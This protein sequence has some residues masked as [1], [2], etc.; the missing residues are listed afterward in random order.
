MEAARAAAAVHFRITQKTTLLF[1]FSSVRTRPNA[2][3][4]L[5]RIYPVRQR[6]D[7]NCDGMALSV[8]HDCDDIDHCISSFT[9]AEHHHGL[10]VEVV[11]EA[12]TSDARAERCRPPQPPH[13]QWDNVENVAAVHK[14]GYSG[15]YLR[16]SSSQRCGYRSTNL[17]KAPRRHPRQRQDAAFAENYHFVGEPWIERLSKKFHAPCKDLFSR[18]LRIFAPNLGKGV[19]FLNA[20]QVVC[21]EH[22]FWTKSFFCV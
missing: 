14:C 15:G 1:L 20:S 10:A 8:E 17:Q 12:G 21:R 3:L 18:K 2:V 5:A 11:L 6:H 13:G 16:V 22:V 9:F 19:F 4:A 7:W